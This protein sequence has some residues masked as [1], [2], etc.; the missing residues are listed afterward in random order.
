MNI[1]QI[2]QIGI[3]AALLLAL[4]SAGSLAALG[5][6]AETLQKVGEARLKVLFWNVY[7]SRLYTRDGT[8]REGQR[9]L[10]LEIEYLIDIPSARLVE[11]TRSEWEAMERD[12]PRQDEWLGEL[13]T[14]WP[15]I[16]AG[17]VLTLDIGEDGAALFQR[18]GETLG[19]LAD[20]E[21]GQHFASIWLSPDCTRPELRMALIGGDD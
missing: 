7:D 10:R 17:D 21:F 9:P 2:R 8:Y 11:R 16:E 12:H 6:S 1:H 19:A 18:N 15:D 4:A 5:N 13:R 20:P 14:L 3:G